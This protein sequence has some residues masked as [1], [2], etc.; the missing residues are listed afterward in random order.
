ML[1]QELH[2]RAYPQQRSCPAVVAQCHPW[3]C[4]TKNPRT[5]IRGDDQC[6]A[7]RTT[8]DC[9]YHVC[10]AASDRGSI[11]L[12]SGTLTAFGGVANSRDI[13]GVPVIDS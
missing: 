4:S 5:N 12:V 10:S 2:P 13:M 1:K 9:C 6:D 3:D 7:D 11:T 8:A